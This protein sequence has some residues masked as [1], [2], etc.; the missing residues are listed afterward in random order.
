[1][2]PESPVADATE[3]QPESVMML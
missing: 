1:V 2:Q 3:P